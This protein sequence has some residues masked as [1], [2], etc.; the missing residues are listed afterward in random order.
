M[1]ME[2]RNVIQVIVTNELYGKIADLA[3]T[4]D[5]SMSSMSVRLIE[6]GLNNIDL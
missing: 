3:R 2:E 4:E 5:R 1:P 6:K